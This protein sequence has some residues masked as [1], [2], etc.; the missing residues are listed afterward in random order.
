MPASNHPIQVVIL[1]DHPMTMDGYLSHLSGA[2][3]IIITGKLNYG[4]Q[5]EPVLERYPA[6]VLLLDIQVPTS[7]TNPNPF[8][9]WH[10]ISRL[11]AQHQ[12]LVILIVTMHDRPALIDAALD[13]GVSGYILKDD[14]TAY[15]ELPAIIRTAA[16]G[17]AYF[18]PLARQ[19]WLERRK[20]ANEPLLSPRQLEALSLCAAYPDESLYDLATRMQIA[21]STLRNLLSR[22]YIKLEVSSR[23]A[24]VAR[25][26]KLNL[27]TPDMP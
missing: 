1:E 20:A 24:A 25:A 7:P 5:L 23:G 22:A 12:S 13:A 16:S 6:D 15:K 27:L 4:E 2:Q 26:R 8:P 3:D 11:L 21:P 17:G 14:Q 19:R 18:S 9:A 10:V